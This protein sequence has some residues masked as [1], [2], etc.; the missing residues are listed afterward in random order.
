MKSYLEFRS[1]PTPR[2]FLPL[3]S[4]SD[5]G[6]V[7]P[8]PLSLPLPPFLT[9]LLFSTTV[10][11]SLSLPL[12]VALRGCWNVFVHL[13]SPPAP[14]CSNT[15]THSLLAPVA[16]DLS[17]SLSIPHPLESVHLFLSSSSLRRFCHAPAP[18]NRLSLQVAVCFA[19][20]TEV[21]S[22]SVWSR[23]SQE[24]VAATAGSGGCAAADR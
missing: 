5:P 16:H 4:W 11:S 12:F 15:R 24:P 6:T 23:T 2:G 8:P 19:V 9:C 17:L 10:V 18:K 14:R 21:V 3:R 22:T 1:P 13:S 20:L 7:S